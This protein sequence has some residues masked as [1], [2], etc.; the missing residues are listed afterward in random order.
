M[1][2]F[3]IYLARCRS[4]SQ[5]HMPLTRSELEGALCILGLWIVLVLMVVFIP[6]NPTPTHNPN[7]NTPLGAAKE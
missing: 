7:Q 6:K 3:E 2:E 5:R 1:N 4:P